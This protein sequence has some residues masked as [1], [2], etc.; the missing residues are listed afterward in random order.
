MAKK[1]L[2]LIETN[3]DPLSPN[4]NVLSDGTYVEEGILK[5]DELEAWLS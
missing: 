4:S 2:P 3:G 5:L 1:V